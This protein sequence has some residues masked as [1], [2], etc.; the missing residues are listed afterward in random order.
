[1]IIRRASLN[2]AEALQKIYAYYVE[3]T[4]VTFEYEAPTV[5]EFR[6]RM[7]H[8]LKFYPYLVAE[9]EGRIL[10]YTY[11]G[12][13]K[14]RAAY[15]RCVETTIYLSKDEKRR[16]IG[17]KLLDALEEA[18]AAQHILNA[19]ACIA[20]SRGAMEESGKAEGVFL[21]SE[22][23]ADR[24]EQIADRTEQI[25]DRTEQIADR[26]EQIADQTEEIADRTEEFT[27]TTEDRLTLDSVLFHEKKGYHLVGT[28]HDCGYKFN[29]WYDM[30]W[31]EKMLGEHGDYAEPVIPFPQEET[32]LL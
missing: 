8:T 20:V 15:D 1:M 24:T 2:D 27:G 25:A 7:Q 19:N 16:G 11:A 31:M 22:Q 21:S 17:S 28:F 12:T 9:E 5:E 13:F 14:D 3:E 18:L 32:I 6:S 4:A 29:K 30:V 26:T 23:I 10:G